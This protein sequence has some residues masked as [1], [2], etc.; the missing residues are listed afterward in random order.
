MRSRAKNQ[1]QVFQVPSL[2]LP[3]PLSK[4]ASLTVDREAH[5]RENCR[6]PPGLPCG[7]LAK[8][9]F[10]WET[11]EPTLHLRLLKALKSVLP[12]S[13]RPQNALWGPLISYVQSLVPGVGT[14]QVHGWQP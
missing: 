10:F 5:T 9:C 6:A 3:T 8:I 2:E 13:C 4:Q 14:A 12:I 11:L 7:T 1:N